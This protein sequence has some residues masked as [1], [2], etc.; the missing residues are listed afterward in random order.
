V[1]SAPQVILA[2]HVARPRCAVP[3]PRIWVR[4][5]EMSAYLIRVSHPDG[6]GLVRLTPCSTFPLDL[7]GSPTRPAPTGQGSTSQ[8]TEGHPAHPPTTARPVCVRA[9][10]R[11]LVGIPRPD[12]NRDQSSSRCR[13]RLPRRYSPKSD[14]RNNVAS[15]HHSY[16]EV[17]PDQAACGLGGFSTLVFLGSGRPVAE[18]N[19][20][21]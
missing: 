20:G 19:R 11:W 5:A 18:L 7:V 14:S 12:R 16:E 21:G 6:G 17:W 1:T 10:I 3:H 8:I 4:E 2:E 15:S 9:S 13:R